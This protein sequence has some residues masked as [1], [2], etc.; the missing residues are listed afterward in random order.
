MLINNYDVKKEVKLV[1]HN[2]I[3]LIIRKKIKLLSF[4]EEDILMTNKARYG[5]IN[6]KI[7]QVIKID[8]L[9]HN[10]HILNDNDNTLFHFVKSYLLIL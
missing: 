10:K 3:L 5:V 6:D 2:D 1:L 7:Y 8:I 4:Q 9:S